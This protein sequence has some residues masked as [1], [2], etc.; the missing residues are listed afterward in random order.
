MVHPSFQNVAQTPSQVSPPQDMARHSSQN[1]ADS[2]S[3]SLKSTSYE[4]M[5]VQISHKMLSV[6]NTAT[7]HP[8]N[9]VPTLGLQEIPPSQ[10]QAMPISQEI[11]NPSLQ[12][13]AS[14]TAQNQG[15]L[16]SQNP[17]SL[18]H[19]MVTSRSHN[20]DTPPSQMQE[21][22]VLQDQKVSR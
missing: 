10:N 7:H 20:Q 21:F 3:R 11:T 18:P 14:S 17:V 16:S 19:N 12:N 15:S 1:S 13:F 9:L 5:P 6:Q 22:Q 8:P 2:S 4:N